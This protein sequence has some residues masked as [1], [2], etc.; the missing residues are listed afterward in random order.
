M[1]IKYQAIKI[2]QLKDE[3]EKAKNALFIEILS[4]SRQ[5]D[6]I[7]NQMFN[8]DN[9]RAKLFEKLKD[10]REKQ[11]RDEAHYDLIIRAQQALTS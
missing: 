8:L 9:E 1:S 4:V 5:I 6:S 10:L 3:R 2:E 11:K 7:T